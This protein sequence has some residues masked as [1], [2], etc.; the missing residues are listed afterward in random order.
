MKKDNKILSDLGRIATSAL[1]TASSIQREVAEYTRQSF[2]SLAKRM[3][4]VTKDE[5]DVLKKII[6]QL[7]KDVQELKKVVKAEAGN[8]AEGNAPASNAKT[9][10]KKSKLKDE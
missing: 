10:R 4:F 8:D 3:N 7:K 6:T 2:E 1:A 5:V 9:A